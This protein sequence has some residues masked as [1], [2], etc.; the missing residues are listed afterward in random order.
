M[1]YVQA[2]QHNFSKI[3]QRIYLDEKMISF[4][5]LESYNQPKACMSHASLFSARRCFPT[6]LKS[7]STILQKHLTFERLETSKIESSRQKLVWRTMIHASNVKSQTFMLLHKDTQQDSLPP[8]M[9]DI[10]KVARERNIGL[11]LKTTGPWFTIIAQ[12]LENGDMRT[13]GKADGFVRPW[14]DGRILHLDSIRM[15]KIDSGNIRSVF[16][17]AL[18]IGALAMRF[19]YDKKC[20]RA[21]LLAINDT[22]EYHSKLVKYYSR[23]GFKVMCEVEGGSLEDLGHMLVWGGVGTR[24]NGDILELLQRWNKVLSPSREQVEKK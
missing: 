23:L 5:K 7:S 17:V 1:A 20:V 22:D 6:N 18:F 12:S 24:M 16:G 4:M 10:I 8:S 21:E 15:A 11:E 13:I 19:G 3:E 14:I 9:A 2:G